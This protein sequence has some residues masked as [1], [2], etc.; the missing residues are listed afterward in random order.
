ML[1]FFSPNMTPE[2]LYRLNDITGEKALKSVAAV[3]EVET[4]YDLTDRDFDDLKMYHL[5]V[6]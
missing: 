6:T 3:E 2:E 4:V 1:A 5:G